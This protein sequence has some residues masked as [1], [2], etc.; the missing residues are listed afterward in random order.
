[1][2]S[3]GSNEMVKRFKSRIATKR[4]SRF[5]PGTHIRVY[6]FSPFR[7]TGK[8]KNWGSDLESAS[9]RQPDTANLFFFVHTT[10]HRRMF[11]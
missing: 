2:A 1:M 9:E 6:I 8:G 11:R 10:R 5:D 7:T 4:K 3:S